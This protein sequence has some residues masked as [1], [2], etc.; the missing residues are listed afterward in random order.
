MGVGM[1]EPNA[2]YSGTPL[3]LS[4][5]PLRSALV[6][7][8]GD[9]LETRLVICAGHAVTDGCELSSLGNQKNFCWCF[10][11]NSAT[12]GEFVGSSR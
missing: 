4:D 6:N 7:G 9:S 3:R 8:A 11:G 10:G 12:G 5:E 1:N 2:K